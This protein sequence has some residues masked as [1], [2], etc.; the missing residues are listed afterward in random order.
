M[1]AYQD[2]HACHHLIDKHNMGYH[3][4]PKEQV[5]VFKKLIKDRSTNYQP[6]LVYLNVYFRS[7]AYDYFFRD[8]CRL[9]DPR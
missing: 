1:T 5:G 7:F 4:R 3:S 8:P 6:L 2:Y 9:R